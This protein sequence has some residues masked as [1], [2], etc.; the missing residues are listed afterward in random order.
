MYIYQHQ[1]WANF[2][3][4]AEKVLSVLARAKLAQGLLLTISEE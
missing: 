2:K 3:W 1:D 4:D